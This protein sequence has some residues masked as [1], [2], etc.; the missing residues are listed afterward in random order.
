MGILVGVIREGGEVGVNELNKS[1]TTAAGESGALGAAEGISWSML[2]RWEEEG[3]EDDSLD[4]PRFRVNLS[5]PTE[6]KVALDLSGISFGGE[7]PVAMFGFFQG[8][9]WLVEVW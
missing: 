8:L 4:I 9:V 3:D 7:S 5:P 6:M 2:M 1:A